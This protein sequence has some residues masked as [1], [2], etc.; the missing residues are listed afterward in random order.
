MHVEGRILRTFATGAVAIAMPL[1]LTGQAAAAP[2]TPDLSGIPDLP[3]VGSI[4]EK[5]EGAAAHAALQA[6]T[7]SPKLS[8]VA[9]EHTPFF[10]T[11]PTIGCGPSAPVTVTMAPSTNPVVHG[12][13]VSFQ[14]L[15]AHP[16]VVTTSL[17]SVAWINTTTGASGIDALDETTA[18]G[19]PSLSTTVH[20]GSGTVVAAMFGT[21]NYA[22]AACHVL[23]TV[24]S[25]YVPEEGPLPAEVAARK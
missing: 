13:A 9:D 25:F 3:G 16:G 23:P 10:Y 8:D 22:T 18:G 1:A 17:L 14:A 19:Y 15:S 5:V 2:F 6:L 4:H 20:T 12:D 24:G 7:A 21:V 11:A